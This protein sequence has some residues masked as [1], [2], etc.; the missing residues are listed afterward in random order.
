[1]QSGARLSK[2][3]PKPKEEEPEV[4]KVVIPEEEVKPVEPE[5]SAQVIKEVKEPRVPKEKFT[6]TQLPPIADDL[7]VEEIPEPVIEEPVIEVKLPQIEQPVEKLG[8]ALPE[9]MAP[10]ERFEV[11]LPVLKDIKEEITA[12][13]RPRMEKSFKVNFTLPR[14]SAPKFKA[15]NLEPNRII[16]VAISLVVVGI[17]GAVTGLLYIESQPSTGKA[18]SAARETLANVQTMN[19][20][21]NAGFDLTSTP[22]DE[23]ILNG[24]RQIEIVM[25]YEANGK[26]DKVARKMEID[27]SF[28]SI[29]EELT[30]D[31]TVIANDVYI[32]YEGR[33]YIQSTNLEDGILTIQNIES[34]NLFPK[35]T[36]TTTFGY[37]AEEVIGSENSYRFRAYPSEDQLREYIVNFVGSLIKK[38]YPLNPPTIVADDVEYTN[39]GY[40]VWV[41]VNS[42]RP[43]KLQMLFDQIDI[44]LGDMGTIKIEDFQV[45]ILLSSLNQAVVI[46]KPI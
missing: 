7:E 30:F 28:K 42:Y 25:V 13:T 12:P 14:I 17:I 16:Q 41:G 2:P 18:L 15:P 19:F 27:G 4:P 22:S 24:S 23:D 29:G 36:N 33:D 46:E 6:I 26:Y 1:M 43:T 9:I 11:E 31:Q 35:F 37:G 34:Q 5:V 45:D 10:Q 8:P 38:L 32:K 44:N 3:T 21:L 40:R 39:S 20:K